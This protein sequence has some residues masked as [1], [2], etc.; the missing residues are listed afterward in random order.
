MTAGAC[1][2]LE[3]LPEQAGAILQHARRAV[4]TTIDDHGRPHAVPICFAVSHGNV[5]TPIDHKPKKTRALARIRHI[6]DRPLATVLFDRYDD[7]WSNLGWVMVRGN[8]RIGS[9]DSARDEL[10]ARYPQYRERPP[11]G[12]LIVIEPERIT[13][14]LSGVG[15]EAE[16][17]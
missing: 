1:T 11:E 5:V 4:L 10:A 15:R 14:W 16:R 3:S 12:P 6:E 2:S 13:W 7:D 17:P 8:A 9:A